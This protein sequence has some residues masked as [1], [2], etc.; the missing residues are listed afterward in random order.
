M[1]QLREKVAF[2]EKQNQA[3]HANTQ[4]ITNVLKSSGSLKGQLSG[5]DFQDSINGN[6]PGQLNSSGLG[7]GGNALQK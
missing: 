5:L 2:L 4:Q 7:F 6:Q 1:I 3:L